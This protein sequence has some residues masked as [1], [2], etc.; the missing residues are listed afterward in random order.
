MTVTAFP[1]YAAR[2]RARPA[3]GSLLRLAVVSALGFV[4]VL[5]GG[6]VFI[7][8]PAVVDVGTVEPTGNPVAEFRI[9]NAGDAPLLITKARAGCA[10]CMTI[11]CPDKPIPPGAVAALKVTLTG[12]PPSGPVRKIVYLDTNDPAKAGV[13][14]T[15]N[16]VVRGVY[17]LTPNPTFALGETEAGKEQSWD[18]ELTVAG[19]TPCAITAVEAPAGFA[20]RV[21]LNRPAQRHALRLTTVPSKLAVGVLQ[22]DIALRTDSPTLPHLRIPLALVV[23]GPV[24][25]SPSTLLVSIPPVGSEA[26]AVQAFPPAQG[27]LTLVAVSGPCPRVEAVESPSAD[28]RA[29]ILP[30]DDGA[31]SRVVEVVIPPGAKPGTKGELVIRMAG[32]NQPRILVPVIA[33]SAT[34]AAAATVTAP[35]ARLH[36]P[37]P[38]LVGRLARHLGCS[39]ASVFSGGFKAERT[40]LTIWLAERLCDPATVERQ[41]RRSA[42][43]GMSVIGYARA[44]DEVTLRLQHDPEFKARCEQTLALV[45]TEETG[46]GGK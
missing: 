46:E 40:Q 5:R 3:A 10:A 37:F 23:K 44:R 8:D 33:V 28:V 30:A 19:T 35:E 43:G 15:V 39:P 42:L 11:D 16:G 34:R 2:S 29:R 36:M 24:M 26:S 27:R 20:V 45:G 7:C 9:R 12:L 31:R 22:G 1:A 14:L 17:V 32:N 18:Y 6:P 41:A 4:G 25:P 13:Q 21:A 38:V